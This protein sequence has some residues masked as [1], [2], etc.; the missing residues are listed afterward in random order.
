MGFNNMNRC[1]ELKQILL[2]NRKKGLT[3]LDMTNFPHY[4]TD[5]RKEISVLRRQAKSE[6]K[7]KNKWQMIWTIAD[8][9]ETS[10][11]RTSRFK[12]YF[13]KETKK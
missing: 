12:R 3:V 4:H 9:W 1:Q 13:Y 10:R 7:S 11:D 5:C 6:A 2:K 8:T